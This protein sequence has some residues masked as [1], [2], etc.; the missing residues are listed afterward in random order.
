MHEY[1]FVRLRLHFL[2]VAS[3]GVE[4]PRWPLPRVMLTIEETK[5]GNHDRGK[6]DLGS[7]RLRDLSDLGVVSPE[8]A[9]F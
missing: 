3:S 6:A 2:G 4:R 8:V 5:S 9:R 7:S 1:G